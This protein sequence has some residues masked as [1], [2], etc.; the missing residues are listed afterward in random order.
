MNQ[1]RPR[2]PWPPFP[3]PVRVSSARRWR[4]GPRDRTRLRASTCESGRAPLLTRAQHQHSGIFACSRVTCLA[5][6]AQL[7]GAHVDVALL[8]RIDPA[9][10]RTI[11]SEIP[12]AAG[13]HREQS[14]HRGSLLSHGHRLHDEPLELRPDHPAVKTCVHPARACPTSAA[15]TRAQA[16]HRQPL[17]TSAATQRPPE[18]C[19]ASCEPARATAL[20]ATLSSNALTSSLISPCV[21][22]KRASVSG[23]GLR[24]CLDGAQRLVERLEQLRRALLAHH[25]RDVLL[26]GRGNHQPARLAGAGTR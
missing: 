2:R 13:M 12:C 9:H 5:E 16:N 14:V 6:H 4:S 18:D 3:C 15:C 8:D 1:P 24:A 10:R 23:A 26:L 19:A 7:F 20:T 11:V 17:A 21:A 25:T 22:A